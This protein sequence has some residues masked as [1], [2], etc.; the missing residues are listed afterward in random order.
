[1]GASAGFSGLSGFS[2]AEGKGRMFPQEGKQG[3]KVGREEWP[4]AV[5]RREATE[6]VCTRERTRGHEEAR[7]RTGKM[8]RGRGS[9]LLRAWLQE[10][11]SCRQSRPDRAEEHR[12][13]R[14]EWG[15]EEREGPL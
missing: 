12:H 6:D 1:M 13:P 2:L 7:L 9:G 15:G 5:V 8:R 10:D 14:G 11:N 3:A 4:W